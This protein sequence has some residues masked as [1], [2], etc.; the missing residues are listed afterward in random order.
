MKKHLLLLLMALLVGCATS[1]KNT[2]APQS[3]EAVITR[4]RV[5]QLTFEEVDSGKTPYD[6][7][8]GKKWEEFKAQSRAGDE[9][10]YFCSP[11]PTWT[12][13]MGW[14]GYAIYRQGKLIAEFTTAEN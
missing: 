1:T 10:W 4:W 12:D 11:G 9:I 2:R 13:M 3:D 5:K 7:P 14:R 8:T 6:K